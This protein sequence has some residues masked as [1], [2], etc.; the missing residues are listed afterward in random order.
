MQMLTNMT[1]YYSK[2]ACNTFTCY[3]M[4]EI[5]I[6]S[7]QKGSPNIEMSLKYFRPVCIFRPNQPFGPFNFR[8]NVWDSLFLKSLR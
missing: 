3:F 1:K 7:K 4:F 5:N 6:F 2:I 8:P